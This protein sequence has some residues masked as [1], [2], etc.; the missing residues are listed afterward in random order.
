MATKAMRQFT[1]AHLIYLNF[2]VIVLSSVITALLG[3]GCSVTA[4]CSTRNLPEADFWTV[5]KIS[6]G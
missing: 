5:S 2:A 1:Y 6:P 3:R 4:T